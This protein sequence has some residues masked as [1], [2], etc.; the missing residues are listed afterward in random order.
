[1]NFRNFFVLSVGLLGL[2]LL[3]PGTTK[4]QALIASPGTSCAGMTQNHYEVIKSVDPPQTTIEISK[5]DKYNNCCGIGDKGFGADS[6]AIGYK[7][8]SSGDFSVDAGYKGVTVGLKASESAEDSSTQTTD[9]PAFIIHKN[10]YGYHGFAQYQDQWTETITIRQLD[11]IAQPMS[12]QNLYESD[13]S[14]PTT[15]ETRQLY[16]NHY[17][18]ENDGPFPC[19]KLGS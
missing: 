13:A 16:Q 1:M 18:G 6:K 4:A 14:Y 17:E 15:T 9:L 2:M 5:P 7:T 12:Y 3:T 11:C 10:Q 8:T 19:V